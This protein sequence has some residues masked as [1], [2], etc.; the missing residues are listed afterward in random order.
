MKYFMVMVTPETV[1]LPTRGHLA[2]D[3]LENKTNQQKK[4]INLQLE[5]DHIPN[6]LEFFK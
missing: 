5:L 6:F 4:T 2:A 3:F 1:Q